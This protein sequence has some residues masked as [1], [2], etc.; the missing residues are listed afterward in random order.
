MKNTKNNRALIA[1][2]RQGNRKVRIG[3]RMGLN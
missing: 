1:I 2:E 3:L